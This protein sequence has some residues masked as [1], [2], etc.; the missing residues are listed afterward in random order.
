MSRY[1]DI[2]QLLTLVFLGLTDGSCRFPVGGLFTQVVSFIGCLLAFT[3]ANFD[4]YTIVGIHIGRERYHGQTF[5]L[6]LNLELADLV[7]MEEEAAW[8]GFLVVKLVAE[9][10]GCDAHARQDQLTLDHA[11]VGTGEVNATRTDGFNLGAFEFD[12]RF[13]AF[14]D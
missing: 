12:A 2:K 13:E 3:H 14:D 7:A 9:T 1:R 10:V 5:L 6:Q 4:F 11:S 8:A